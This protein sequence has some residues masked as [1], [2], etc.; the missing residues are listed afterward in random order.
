M[1]SFRYYPHGL[2]KQWVGSS[3]RCARP[4]QHSWYTAWPPITLAYGL[5]SLPIY[6]AITRAQTTHKESWH[7]HRPLPWHIKSH[8]S[9]TEVAC[10]VLGCEVTRKEASPETTKREYLFV[11]RVCSI[12]VFRTACVTP[13]NLFPHNAIFVETPSDL[14]WAGNSTPSPHRNKR[15]HISVSAH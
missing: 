3:S 1:R 11:R 13:L 9:L 14:T 10:P 8:T 4:L 2:N 6:A 7:P 5:G 15:L 12:F